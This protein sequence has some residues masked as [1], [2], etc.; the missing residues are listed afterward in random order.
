MRYRIKKP[1]KKPSQL[2]TDEIGK[3]L[4]SSEHPVEMDC[5]P[6]RL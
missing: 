6:A 3:G 1:N 4:P 2:E 5:F